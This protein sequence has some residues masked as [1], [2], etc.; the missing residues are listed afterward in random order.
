MDFI[1]DEI[2]QFL[3]SSTTPS[4]HDISQNAPIDFQEEEKEVMKMKQSEN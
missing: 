4:G 1:S 3:G 2:D